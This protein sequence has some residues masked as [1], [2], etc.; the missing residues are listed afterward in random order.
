MKKYKTSGI[1]KY[2]IRSRLLQFFC[3]VLHKD[4]RNAVVGRNAT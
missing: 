2:Q 4:M 3:Y 1:L